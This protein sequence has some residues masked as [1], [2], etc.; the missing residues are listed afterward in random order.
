MCIR[1]SDTYHRRGLYPTELP[2]VLGGEGAGVVAALG[3][4]VKTLKEGDRVAYAHRFG[5]YSEERTI[6]ADRLVKVPDGIEDASA[7][8]MML[9]GM[10][11]QYLL[12]QIYDVKAGDTILFHAAA[13]GVGLI[14][15]Q[16]ANALGATVIGTVGSEEKAELAR[17]NGCHHV[18]DYTKEDFVERV[19]EI[20]GGAGLPVVYDSVGKDT[21]EGSVNCLKR[22][23]LWVLFGQSS[24]PVPPFDLGRLTNGSLFVTRPT[25]VDYAASRAELEATAKDLFDVVKSGKV[26][27]HIGQEFPL[28]EAAEAHRALESRK[29]VGA[30]VLRP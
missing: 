21:Y 11:C 28:A 25:L 16:W 27:I 8:A 20:S 10:T 7:A 17:A 6:A 18:I 24:G 12:R 4:E 30:S 29:T 1:D 19:R 13:G 2:I 26:N 15:C 23:G 22:R 5:A 3:S 9:K 14:A